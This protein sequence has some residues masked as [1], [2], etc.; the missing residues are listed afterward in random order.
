MGPR[1][2]ACFRV[3]SGCT[4][5]YKVRRC[6]SRLWTDWSGPAGAGAPSDKRK[7]E[8]DALKAKLDGGAALSNKERRR[9]KDLE[10]SFVEEK[11][12]KER[13]ESDLANFSVSH[14]SG[15]GSTQVGVCCR[16]APRC[17]CPCSCCHLCPCPMPRS[18][19]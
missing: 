7:A 5:P 13:V 18:V 9:L 14:A 2:C 10:D 4:L 6:G 17:C 11:A 3:L 8:Y 15:S 1:C 16:A 12:F 19:G